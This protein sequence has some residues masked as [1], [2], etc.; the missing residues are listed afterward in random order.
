MLQLYP[1]SVFRERTGCRDDGYSLGH[2]DAY[3]SSY[4]FAND[5]LWAKCD[6]NVLTGHII[7][8]L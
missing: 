8:N 2:G 1:L 7:E 4:W 5:T 6:L 3:R